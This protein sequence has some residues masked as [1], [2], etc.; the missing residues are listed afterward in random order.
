MKFKKLIA[1]L[2]TTITAAC[3]S[4]G[5]SGCKEEED[6]YEGYKFTAEAPIIED[7]TSKDLDLIEWFNDTGEY[8]RDYYDNYYQYCFDEYVQYYFANFAGSNMYLFNYAESDWYLVGWQ[9]WFGFYKKSGTSDLIIEVS[10]AFYKNELGSEG[11]EDGSY[12]GIKRSV[13]IDML[14]KPI[15]NY[16]KSNFNFEFG[17]TGN[18]KYINVFL[19]DEGFATCYFSNCVPVQQEWWTNFITENL[20]WMG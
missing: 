1:I 11:S 15:S 17:K 6:L 10:Y 9:P 20:I 12:T 13:F 18:R 2:L 14:V 5:F 16:K 19:G 8:D 3:I 4:V 7:K